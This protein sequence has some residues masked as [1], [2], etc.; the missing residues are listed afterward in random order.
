MDDNNKADCNLRRKVKDVVSKSTFW[1]RHGKDGLQLCLTVPLF[2]LGLF[3]VRS[4]SMPVF[5]LGTF[6]ISV[7]HTA[8]G[9]RG[10]HAAVHGTLTSN[11]TINKFFGYIFSDIV[12]QFSCHAGYVTHVKGHHP[13]TNVIGYG[14]SST[15][16]A[17]FL[18]RFVYLFMLPFLLPFLNPM[19]SLNILL[20]NNN[21]WQHMSLYALLMVFG[22]A[23][24]TSLLIYVSNLTL[25]MTLLVMYIRR[26]T[27]SM[28][29]LHVNVFQHIG[30]KFYEFQSR[31]KSKA[32]QMTHSVLN[33]ANCGILEI[34]FGAGICS[35]HI[36]H[37]LFPNLSDNM[38]RKIRPMVKKELLRNGLP[39]FERSYGDRLALFIDKYEE[40][41]VD[42]PSI[43]SMAGIQ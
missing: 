28:P 16:K 18:S 12:N 5:L 1:Q 36:E 30:L 9:F 35:C 20:A 7:F 32:Y 17:P 4:T 34:V 8:I 21:F 29:F 25:G 15:F 41:L 40:L 11:A 22:L 3:L 23:V 13:Y 27:F 24:E 37:H 10:S 38:L 42:P 33:L 14:D 6:M 19:V 26:A 39:Y 2:G 43:L 31:P